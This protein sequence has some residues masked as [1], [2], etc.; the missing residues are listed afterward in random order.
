[1]GDGLR[2]QEVLVAHAAAIFMK[3]GYDQDGLLPY[4]VFCSVLF[5][6][7]NRLLGM[8]RPPA[9]VIQR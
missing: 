8:V 1:M 2:A 5:T 3:C 6:G 4:D 7:P 9:C